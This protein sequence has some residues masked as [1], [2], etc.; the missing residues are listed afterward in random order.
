MRG[1]RYSNRLIAIAVVRT[2]GPLAAVLVVLLLLAARV[3]LPV[4]RGVP[5]AMSL[6]LLPVLAAVAAVAIFDA[7][8]SV[9]L[10]RSS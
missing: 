6:A 10:Y 8:L 3:L 4:A 1:F 7:Q 2:A 9:R 5:V